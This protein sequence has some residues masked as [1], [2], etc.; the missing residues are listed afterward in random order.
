[1]D[2][3]AEIFS[4]VADM[5]KERIEKEKETGLSEETYKMISLT[6]RLYNYDSASTPPELF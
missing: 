2:K 5:T 6:L 3:I 1:M 4:M